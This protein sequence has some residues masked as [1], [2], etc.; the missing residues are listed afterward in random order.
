MIQGSAATTG[1]R[2]FATNQ[3]TGDHIETTQKLIVETKEMLQGGHVILNNNCLAFNESGDVNKIAQW[4]EIGDEIEFMG[5]KHEGDYHLE[6]IK[7]T[8]STTA[9]RPIC[10]CGTRMKSMGKEQGVRCPKCKKRSD[11][12]WTNEDRIPPLH[13]WVQPPA[14]KRRHLAKSLT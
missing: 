12:K 2:I 14:D 1:S 7:V 3:A 11:V 10:E 5:L 9:K 8:S 6:A 13:G 4:L